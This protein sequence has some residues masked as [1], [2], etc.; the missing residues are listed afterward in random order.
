MPE[1]FLDTKEK[2]L[3]TPGPL[4]TN[5]KTRQAML[6]DLG[7]RDID[8]AELVTKIRQRLLKIAGCNGQDYDTIPIPGSGT[9]G[10]E[11]VLSSV[12][13][14]TDRLLILDNGAY[15]RRL[16]MIAKA[17]GLPHETL[18]F[19]DHEIIDVARVESALDEG[20][21][22]HI[23][24]IHC[25]T[26]TGMLNPLEKIG[27]VAKK[28]Q[29]SLIVDAMSSFAGVP[30]NVPMAPVDYLVSSS[31]KCVEGVPGFCFVIANT[32]KLLASEGKARTM[33][34]DLLAQY[35]G[36]AFD[37][38]FRFTPP[39]HVIAAFDQALDIL[40]REGGVFARTQR[41]QTNHEVLVTAMKALGFLCFL[42]AEH[43]S[44][45]ITSFMYPKH[46]NFDFELF[47]Q[48]LKTRG[49]LIYQGKLSDAD[50]FRVGTIGHIFP[51]DIENLIDAIQRTLGE[52]KIPLPV[53]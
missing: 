16:D 40:D 38:R 24:M 34:L 7:S 1:V 15:G 5:H 36:F 44:P 3:F 19:L 35:R 2:I 23:A 28:Y 18:R 27:A 13:G 21:F 48:K 30:I 17:H 33:S 46:A 11:S 8:F 52:M 51:H 37:G 41:Y 10:V 42:P 50:C 39:T 22:N 4:T 25:E 20:G 26:S 49:Y 6:S 47:Y 53:S 12:I 14:P 9:Y 45:I 31:N 43:Q 32:K 29:A